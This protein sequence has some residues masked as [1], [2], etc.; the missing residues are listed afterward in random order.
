MS[1]ENEYKTYIY[2]ISRFGKK[3]KKFYHAKEKRH[4][5]NENIQITNYIRE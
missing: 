1:F 5:G 3:R 4:I 2:V